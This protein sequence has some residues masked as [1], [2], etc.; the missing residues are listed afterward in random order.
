MQANLLKWLTGLDSALLFAKTRIQQSLIKHSRNCC[1]IVAEEN[2]Y[3][4]L[5]WTNYL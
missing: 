5:R 2:R 4:P 3:C 1:Q